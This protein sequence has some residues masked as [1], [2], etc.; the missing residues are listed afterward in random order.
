MYLTLLQIYVSFKFSYSCSFCILIVLFYVCIFTE[1]VDRPPTAHPED[2]VDSELSE[3]DEYLDERLDYLDEISL[4]VNPTWKRR[5]K[6]LFFSDTV[7][8]YHR[9][10]ITYYVPT[11]PAYMFEM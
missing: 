4:R 9:H 2:D 8:T 6:D 5:I 3:E 11:T 7:S 1:E 10:I